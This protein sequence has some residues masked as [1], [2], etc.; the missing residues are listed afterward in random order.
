M[1]EAL[2]ASQELFHATFEQ[3]AVGIAHLDLDG[4]FIR[5][6][7]HL[8]ELLGYT[9]DELLRMTF[10]E[11]TAPEDRAASRE[12][13]RALLAANR[14]DF[15][16]EKRYIRKNGETLW[17]DLACTLARDA[18]GASQYFVSVV[19]DIS[20]RKLAEA[21]LR[22]LNR[23]HR[24]LS[25]ANEII[26]RTRDLPSLLAEVCRLAVDDGGMRMASVGELV[27][28]GAG[29]VRPV[30][31]A[32][33]RIEQFADLKL[34]ADEGPFGRGTIGTVLR[35]GQRDV[36]NDVL[37]DPRM[38]PWR[39]AMAPFG[40]RATASFP[41]VVDGRP[42]FALTLFATEPDYFQDDELELMSAVASN[43]AFAIETA[44]A[45]ERRVAVERDLRVSEEQ[46][47]LSERQYRLVFAGSPQAMWVYDLES[48]QFLAVNAAA[49][50]RYGYSESEFLKR[51]ILDIRPAEDVEKVRRV[52]R[53]AVTTPGA[54]RHVKKDGTLI[55]VAITS[56]VVEFNGRP[57]R[58]VLAEDVTDRRRAEADAARATRAL[59]MLTACNE[60]MIRA[61]GESML[62]DEICRIA[63]DV[64]GFPMAWVGMAM[65]DP[66]RTI[67]PRAAAGDASGY[68]REIRLSWDARS[69]TGSG[70][71][72][73]AIREGRPIVV[74]DLAGD[75]GGF[76]TVDAAAARGYRGV[77]SLPLS[78][79]A[80]P[81][82]VLTLY[83]NE[84]RDL[85]DD[86]RQ[87]LEQL[88][89]DLAFGIG[90]LRERAER[91]RTD[92]V[93]R[94]QA[95]LLD[96]AQDA[97]IV[98]DL[99]H[100]ITFWN[101]SAERLFGWTADEALGQSVRDLLHTDTAAFDT[102]CDELVARGD[103]AGEF[104]L[105]T[106]SGRAVAVESRWTLVRGEGDV[107]RT[108]LVINTDVTDRK[109]LEQQFLRA[110]RMESIGTLAGGIA[111]DLNNVL[112]PI[113]MSIEL[114]KDN[115][116]D[117]LR[118]ELLSTIQTS[119]HRGA[120]MV[121][122]VLGFARG[123]DGQRLELRVDDL[124]QDVRKI[125]VETL[126]KNIDVHATVDGDVWP[127]LG[128]PTQL[129]QVLLNLIVNARDAMPA[130]G[131]LLLEA[132][133]AVI[134]AD[135][136]AE[137]PDAVAG[138]YVHL[139]V[140]DTGTGIPAH[141]REKIFDPFFTTKELSKG[142][143]LGL[144][145]SL[146]IVRSHGGFFRVYSE[147]NRG[148]TFHV[149]L[150]AH[151][152][153][154]RPVQARVEPT[155]PRGNGEMVLLVDD[156]PP[157]RQITRKILERFGYVVLEAADGAQAVK[158]YRERSGEIAVILTDMMM[159]VMDGPAAIR[160]FVAINAGVRII[161]GS[162]VDQQ[163]RGSEAMDP[164]VKAFL[165]KPYTA[166]AL[167]VALRDVLRDPESFGRT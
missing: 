111:H 167:L 153:A 151:T 96:K 159:P 137:T 148:T 119:A 45:E 72:A 131:R 62:L 164:S 40:I 129:H 87:V 93:M 88:A 140:H 63:V 90:T 8:C 80:P 100:V 29:E 162:G 120:D 22:R 95:S 48:L 79:G 117:P 41:V 46:L 166:D 144:S 116:R 130:G 118:L 37:S 126:P 56:N 12:A 23:L 32:G 19:Q 98:R 9:R 16:V 97:I 20:A 61:E 106:R 103:W 59:Q 141:V 85:P 94:E 44:A 78:N 134:G 163:S 115:E 18:S 124:L 157:V 60:A 2:R 139:R 69:P 50:R 71:A 55:D 101:R 47:R 36:C 67:E 1:S 21:R 84:V 31:L 51:T 14:T 34:S 128:D 112:T 132:R 17:A 110:Q 152:G 54:W 142:T 35:T 43:L 81:F 99:G 147:M 104:T 165:Q 125:A 156:E 68:L 65:D 146:A 150:P 145:T 5:V 66:E 33:A 74:R 11:L 154:A 10:E 161:A 7:Q 39:A 53:Q 102:A 114:L 160:Q 15:T 27:P 4:R 127:L 49:I 123:V 89:N 136:A 25:R 133:N 77:V 38:E 24:V 76:V 70:P 138:S 109:R 113:V 86:E 158:L 42:V 73:R 52:A 108:V 107:A 28:G 135:E 75:P 57:A 82:G 26:I 122:Q 105:R 64:G 3:A 13:A 92:A 83:L 91:R 143:G 155:L 149:Y 6:N 30:A 121:R 58:L